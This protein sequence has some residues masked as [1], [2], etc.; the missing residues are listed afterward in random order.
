MPQPEGHHQAGESRRYHRRK[1][2]ARRL[3]HSEIEAL[4][5]FPDDP[6]D[7]TRAMEARA[8]LRLVEEA[9]RE[10]SPRRR[11]IL[12]AVRLDGAKHAE[13]ARRLGISERLVDMELR[14]AIEHCTRRLKGK[15]GKFF[16]FGDSK[17]SQS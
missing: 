4:T 11:T 7:T 16:W 2:E 9:I 3:T 12:T 6:L 1:S 13:V 15:P 5:Y 14:A 17:P 8:E 10:L